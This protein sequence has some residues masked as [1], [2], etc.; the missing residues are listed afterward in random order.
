VVSLSNQS[1]HTYLVTN[2]QGQFRLITLGR[3]AIG[4]EMY[5]VLATLQAGHGSHLTP[6]AAPI[7]LIPLRRVTDPAFGRIARGGAHYDDY[8]ATLSRVTDKGFALFF[9]D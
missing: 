4:G 7:A 9:T 5:G 2:V 8:R 6:A 3:P 1:G